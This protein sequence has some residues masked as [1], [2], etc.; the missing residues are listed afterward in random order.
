MSF[1]GLS[2]QELLDDCKNH[3]VSDLINLKACGCGVKLDLQDIV[4]PLLSEK[5]KNYSR[6][7][8]SLMSGRIKYVGR[9]NNQELNRLDTVLFNNSNKSK[10]IFCSLFSVE[11]GYYQAPQVTSQRFGNLLSV[12]NHFVLSRSN[13]SKQLIYGKSH[14]IEGGGDFFSLDVFEQTTDN[15]NFI[16]HLNHDTIITADSLLTTC[17]KISIFTA[18]NN[19]LNDLFVN[20]VFQNLEIFPLYDDSSD[21]NINIIKSHLKLYEQHFAKNGVFVKVHDLPP[22]KK[23][24]SLIGATV[25]GTS[26]KK[27]F[28][29]S[30]LKPGYDILITRK[31]GDLS[32]LA[33]NR[34]KNIEGVSISEDVVRDRLEVLSRFSTPQFEFAKILSKYI[35]DLNENFD[36]RKHI[37]FCTDLSGPG[38][39]VLE[40]AADLSQISIRI[41]QLIFY[42]DVYLQQYRRNHTSSTNGPAAIVGHV[43]VLSQLR[44]ELNAVGLTESWYLGKTI[45][46]GKKNIILSKNLLKYSNDKNIRHDLFN[47]EVHFDDFKKRMSIF[48][49]YSFEE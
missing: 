4:Y 9:F 39:S 1:W 43:D 21:E 20:G 19:A 47:P 35:P 31:L 28:D 11:K 41:D 16:T 14:S 22:L 2:T 46:K 27:P 44:N 3:S 6:S 33:Y 7:D 34:S 38:L 42:A 18:L 13:L 45:A 40:E 17:S 8:T 49:S 29:F 48:Q 10:N 32:V 12:L 23:G 30:N 36:D 25:Q 15:D 5:L 26:T 37:L 24:L